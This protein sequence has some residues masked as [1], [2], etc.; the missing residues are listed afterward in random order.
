MHTSPGFLFPAPEESG[1]AELTRLAH[2]HA[3]IAPR[4]TRSKLRQQAFFSPRFS[5]CCL[6]DRRGSG[7][8][9]CKDVVLWYGLLLTRAFARRTRL[10]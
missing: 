2:L 5:G 6:A 9:V 4:F 7:R 1:D 8:T 10:Q 3:R